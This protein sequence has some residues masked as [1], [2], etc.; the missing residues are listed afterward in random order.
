MNVREHIIAERAELVGL[1]SSL[2]PEQWAT[3]SLCA[4]WSVRDVAGHLAID[5]VPLHRYVLSAFRN[6]SAD[7]LN[8]HYVV[9]ARSLPPDRLVER[10]SVSAPS[11]WM[12]RFFPRLALADH[13][14]H[15]QDIRRPL[16]MQR[17]IDADRLRL[18]LDRPDPFARPGRFVEGLRFVATDLPWEK[19]TGPVVRG[20][21]EALALAT[22]GRAAVLDELDGDGVALLRDR[23]VCLSGPSCDHKGTRA[24]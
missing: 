21:G 13:L 23:L 10:L 15:Q 9:A 18:V 17:S 12:T 8:T 22:V 14:V 16:G 6:P 20:S 4:G 2:S 5:A 7:R 24:A 1:L 11:S 19:G 3:P